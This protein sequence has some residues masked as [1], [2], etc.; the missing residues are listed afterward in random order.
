VDQEKYAISQKN[1]FVVARVRDTIIL[2]NTCCSR[3]VDAAKFR[4]A[5]IGWNEL[6]GR[7]GMEFTVGKYRA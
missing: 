4:P 3:P 7:I 2:M 5:A 1:L 6:L